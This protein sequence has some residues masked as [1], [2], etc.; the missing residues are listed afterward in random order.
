M[1]SRQKKWIVPCWYI[2][3]LLPSIIEVFFGLTV[4]STCSGVPA[5]TCVSEMFQAC[6][7]NPVTIGAEH[8]IDA[9]LVQIRSESGFTASQSWLGSHFGHRP[10]LMIQICF[11]LHGKRAFRPTPTEIDISDLTVSDWI[12]PGPM[13]S[14]R[15]QK[16]TRQML[17]PPSLRHHCIAQSSSD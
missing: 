5:S 8:C 2:R 12:S 3:Q 14:L 1:Q 13:C 4:R 6:I 11:Y 7:S 15:G 16:G 9:S 10:L 17:S